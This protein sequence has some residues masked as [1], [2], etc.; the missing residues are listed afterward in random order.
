MSYIG[1]IIWWGTFLQAAGSLKYWCRFLNKVRQWYKKT[2]I[3]MNGHWMALNGQQYGFLKTRDLVQCSRGNIY[4]KINLCYFFSFFFTINILLI[5]RGSR[6]E[7]SKC[8]QRL[9][10]LVIN[11]RLG[12]LWKRQNSDVQ[13]ISEWGVTF[14]ANKIS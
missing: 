10:Y 2:C 1:I 11:E 9:S 12:A 14:T 8:G 6:S 7:T 3:E 4:I 13:I 5:E